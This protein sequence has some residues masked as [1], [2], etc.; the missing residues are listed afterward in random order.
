MLYRILKD[1]PGSQNGTTTENFKA[2]TEVEL[3]DYLAGI[4]VPEGWAE[5]VTPVQAEIVIE[6]K[7]VITDGAADPAGTGEI[8]TKDGAGVVE[9]V[10]RNFRK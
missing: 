6:N 7:A 3:S 5:P 8:V 2:G 4:V 10:K 1:F 9:R